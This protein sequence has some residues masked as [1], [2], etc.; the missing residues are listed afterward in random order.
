MKTTVEVVFSTDSELKNIDMATVASPAC[1]QCPSLSWTS[2]SSPSGSCLRP[3]SLVDYLSLFLSAIR[4][5][6]LRT[7]SVRK[8]YFW[9]SRV[10]SVYVSVRGPGIASA[11]GSALPRYPSFK[12]TPAFSP[13]VTCVVLCTHSKCVTMSVGLPGIWNTHSNI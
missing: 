13:H 4:W 8:K 9:C 7:L 6:Q 3:L 11:H 12:T 2:S 1:H 10:G 5:C